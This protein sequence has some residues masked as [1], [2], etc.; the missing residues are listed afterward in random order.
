[1][2]SEFG[3]AGSKKIVYSGTTTITTTGTGQVSS[4]TVDGQGNVLSSTDPGGTVATTYKSV[5]KPA[6]VSSNGV[7]V[8]MTYDAFGRQK[9]LTDPDAGTTSYDYDNYPNE[10]SSQ[11]DTLGN[12]Y[13]MTYGVLGLDSIRT[14]P[15]GA[16]KYYYDK[17][18]PGQLDS[19]VYPNV[20]DSYP[21]RL[22]RKN[23]HK[24]E[25]NYR[26]NS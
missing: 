14:G 1:M 20:K 11:R 15:E 10:I 16:T 13:V 5:G 19:V 12:I 7:A 17:L 22:Q 18:N 9:S 24:N 26:C 21:Y 4:T 8:T 2:I 6:A 23:N 3:P 25:K